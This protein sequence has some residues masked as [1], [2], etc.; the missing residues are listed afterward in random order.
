MD[1]SASA[2]GKRASEEPTETTGTFGTVTRKRVFFWRSGSWF[3]GSCWEEMALVQITSVRAEVHRHIFGGIL[4]ALCGTASVASIR[5]VFIGLSV[6]VVLIALALLLV[7]GLPVVHIDI[8]GRG[9]YGRG[10]PWR[11]KE[12]FAFAA[13][14][15]QQL[16]DQ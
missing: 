5:P 6:G 8:A 4:L 3:G 10:W 1:A 13:A 15:K 14:I 12:A 16:V 2:A 7:W 9:C 11:R